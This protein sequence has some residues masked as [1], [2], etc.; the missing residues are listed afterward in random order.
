MSRQGALVTIDGR[1]ALRFERRYGHAIE[2]VWS[3]ISEPSEMPLW[4]PSNVEGD[5]VMGAELTFAD[6]TQRATAREAGQPTRADGPTFRG[7][8]VAYDP[9]KVFSFTWGGELLRFELS[10]DGPDT[11]LVFTHLLSHQSIAART[12]AGWHMCLIQ[13]DRLLRSPAV[14]DEDTLAVYDD[15]LQRVGPALGVPSGDGSM[16][17]E[18]STHVEPDRVRSATKEPAEIEAWGGTERAVDPLRWDI[19]RSEHGTIYRLTHDA[20]GDDAELAAKW[21]A[22]LIQLDMYLAAGQLIPVDGARWVAAYG[23]AL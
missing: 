11:V 19:E 1:V 16:M 7:T 15:Y 2:R 8:I 13:L 18:R 23:R 3:A 22:L 14:A 9:P 4:F 6:D 20:V 21:H 17:W 10:S 12:G 5:R